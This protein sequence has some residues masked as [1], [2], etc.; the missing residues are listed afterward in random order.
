[1]LQMTV[2]KLY[3][4]LKE[5]VEKGQGDKA[6]VV[7]SDNEGNSYHGVFYSCTSDPKS[8]KENIDISNGLYDSAITDPAKIV[9]V[10]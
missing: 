9:I 10:G 2:N 6:I 7:A 3:L 5:L 8:V 1:M 4:E